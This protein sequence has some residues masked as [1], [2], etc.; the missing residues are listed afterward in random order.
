MKLE[1]REQIV[2]PDGLHKGAIIG[3]EYRE[4]PYNYT[5]L[6]IEFLLKDDHKFKIKAGFPTIISEVSS[7]GK[8]MER[9]G[10]KLV[11][12]ESLDPDDL[13][14]RPCTFQTIGEEKDGKTYAK[15]LPDSVKPIKKD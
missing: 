8:L 5:D 10:F 6:I 4:K 9:F 15:V 1:V 2:I 12:G 3:V 14:G 7:L 13:I 11:A